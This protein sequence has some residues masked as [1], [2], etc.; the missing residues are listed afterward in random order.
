MMDWKLEFTDI[1]QG[2][3]G[4][5]I[6]KMAL[7]HVVQH[8]IENIILLREYLIFLQHILTTPR[9]AIDDYGNVVKRIY[10]ED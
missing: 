9:P 4:M 3:L 6:M 10:D 7:R 5:N 1:K 2:K 8:W